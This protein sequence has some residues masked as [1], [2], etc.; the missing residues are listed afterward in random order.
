MIFDMPPALLRTLTRRQWIVLARALLPQYLDQAK[1]RGMHPAFVELCEEYE[2]QKAFG[3]SDEIAARR[4]GAAA[5]K[6]I[7]AA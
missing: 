2:Q 1:R 6:E 7:Q 4:A 3:I 5:F